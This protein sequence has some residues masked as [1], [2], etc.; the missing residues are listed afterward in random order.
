MKRVI[1]KS[2][3][4]KRK[5]SIG[6]A[7][8][9]IAVFLSVFMMGL[10][11]A[12][13]TTVTVTSASEYTDAINAAVTTGDAT[14]ILFD[15]GLAI[16]LGSASVPVPSN[17]TLNLT[18]GTLS[19]SGTISVSGSISGG[20]LVINGGTLIR[21]PGSSITA[22]ITVNSGGVVRAPYTLSL[23]NLDTVSVGN[24]V[25][26]SYIGESGQDSSSFVATHS[27]TETL[28]TQMTGSNYSVYKIIDKVTTTSGYVFRLGTKNTST[29]SLVYSL[30]YDGL[31]GAKLAALN[32]TSYTESDAAITLTNPT[33]DG[34]TFVGW[35]CASLGIVVP[36]D[37]FTIAS[38][39]S[40]D[41]TFTAVWVEGTM[42]GGGMSASGGGGTTATTTDTDATDDAEQA[43][44]SAAAADTAGSTTKRV[45]QAS[46]ATKVTFT[47]E[48]NPVLPTL[49]SIQTPSSSFP[50]GWVFGGLGLLGVAAYA[51]AKYID[52]K[53]RN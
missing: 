24:I 5:R 42:Q 16:D 22:A 34:F 33:K 45:K 46:S 23:E 29:L 41:L 20:A 49:D 53:R 14:T 43:Q 12:G 27:P 9:L 26:V 51:L 50:W 44:N 17:V 35:S 3:F 52:R 30:S 4:S 7:R 37:T 1:V 8:V 47:S 10:S 39:T 40:G 19:T 11:F 25:S 6:T 21:K 38:G 28:Y 13:T 18:G 15:A 32:P 31:T 48:T 2:V 36:D